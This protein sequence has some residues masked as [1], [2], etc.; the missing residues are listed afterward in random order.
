MTLPSI[1]T[2]A[3]TTGLPPR[4]SLRTGRV[5]APVGV[6]DPSYEAYVQ[7][8]LKQWAVDVELDSNEYLVSCR[9]LSM[10]GNEREG[11]RRLPRIPRRGADG[12]VLPGDIV[13]V[14]FL[15]G[16]TDSAVVLGTLSPSDHSVDLSTSDLETFQVTTKDLN[17]VQDRLE[18]LDTSNPSASLVTAT[19]SRNTGLMRETEHAGE[20]WVNG[21]ILSAQLLERSYAGRSIETEHRVEVDAST[22]AVLR[23]S[24][25]DAKDLRQ[26]HAVETAAGVSSVIVED[27]QAKVLS[28]TQQVAQLNT[29]VLRSMEGKQLLLQQ[30]TPVLRTTAISDSDT[31][32]VSL[33]VEDRGANTRAGWTVGPRGELILRRS[34]SD[35]KETT[36]SLTEDGNLV[37]QTPGGASVLIDDEDILVSTGRASITVS[38]AS[39]VHLATKEGTRVTMTDDAVAVIGPT[40][41]VQAGSVHLKTGGLLVGDSAAGSKFVPDA[42]KVES[43]IRTLQQRLAAL[44]AAFNSHIHPTGSPGSPTG[45]SV[46]QATA[47]TPNLFLTVRD[48][49]KSVK[50]V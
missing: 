48:S 42:D 31:K 1:L 21:Q 11:V 22:N 39:G 7:R 23:T 10:Q 38:E 32:T 14:A 41:T 5:T 26:V 40:C 12:A 17:E 13:L 15:N 19:M 25:R 20:T 37:M 2:A 47:P 36:L 9:V 45:L 8:C 28:L 16:H 44:T 33:V 46:V 49:L 27:L 30:E 35:N 6:D 18:H 3:K 24:D 34:G 4:Y 43:A 50:G 29:F